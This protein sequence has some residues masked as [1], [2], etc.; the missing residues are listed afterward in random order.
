MLMRKCVAVGR[1]SLM[2]IVLGGLVSLLGCQN[3][4]DIAPTYDMIPFTQS[5]RAE[6]NLTPM[7]IKNLQFYVSDPIHLNQSISSGQTEVVRGKLVLKSGKFV[8]EVIVNRGTPG[9]AVDVEDQLVRVSFEEKTSMAFVKG[10]AT[11]PDKYFLQLQ[12]DDSGKDAVNFAGAWYA[13]R[14]NTALAHLLIAKGDLSDVVNKR[15]VLPGRR[16]RD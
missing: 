1:Q 15:R 14:E 4:P 3:R 12:K 16:I 9:I 10:V 5:L 6:H 7:E 8:E 11:D 13:P 2:V